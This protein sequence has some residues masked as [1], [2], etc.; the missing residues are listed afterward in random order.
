M[1]G[2]SVTFCCVS[3]R[4]FFFCFFYFLAF[5]LLRL[6]S[7]KVFCR[8]IILCNAVRF[9]SRLVVLSRSLPISIPFSLLQCRQFT[10]N[11]RP[12]HA[13]HGVLL[14]FFGFA[15]CLCAL[16]ALHKTW[17]K[18]LERARPI[19][20]CHGF[21]PAEMRWATETGNEENLLEKWIGRTG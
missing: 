21:G 11:K 12:S 20:V 10:T 1:F 14:C 17:I 7:L 15:Y 2:S 5:F 6:C 3:L 16:W 4:Q 18:F 8:F 19:R 13:A 9:H